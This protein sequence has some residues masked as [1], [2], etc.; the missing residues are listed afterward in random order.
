ML[1]TD[2]SIKTTGLGSRDDQDGLLQSNKRT[3]TRI[4]STVLIWHKRFSKVFTAGL[5]SRDGHTRHRRHRRRPQ[6]GFLSSQHFSERPL[7]SRYSV[8]VGVAFHS[9]PKA[10]FT[11]N[12]ECTTILVYYSSPLQPL[13]PGDGIIAD[14]TKLHVRAFGIALVR[15]RAGQ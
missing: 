2:T 1:K 9:P 14:A 3:K 4:S 13:S 12:G 10:M 8:R 15:S 11:V 5:V 7:C 6:Y